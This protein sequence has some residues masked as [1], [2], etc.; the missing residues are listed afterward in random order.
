MAKL[1]TSW[2]VSTRVLKSSESA[3]FSDEILLQNESFR[4]FNQKESKSK[5]IYEYAHIS[6]GHYFDS[7]KLKDS[8]CR[9]DGS[10][11]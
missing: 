8:R 5:Q 11:P 4:C 7:V 3:D 10:R 2:P 1:S 6:R 9:Q